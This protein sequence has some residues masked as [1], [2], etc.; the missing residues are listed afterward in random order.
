[1]LPNP[2]YGPGI[3][4][5]FDDVFPTDKRWADPAGGGAK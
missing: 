3:R 4:G 5:G 1:M 2:V